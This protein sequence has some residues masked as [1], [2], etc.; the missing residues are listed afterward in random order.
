M[1]TLHDSAN[2]ETSLALARAALNNPR[3]RG[4]AEGLAVRTAILTDEAARPAGA[5]KI[6]RA[7]AASSGNRC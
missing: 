2:Q 3:P 7:H 4:N 5:F 1:A 6:C